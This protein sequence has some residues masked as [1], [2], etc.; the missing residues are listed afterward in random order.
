M[1]Q[2]I[3][4]KLEHQ[5]ATVPERAVDPIA[6]RQSLGVLEN[7]FEVALVELTDTERVGLVAGQL[8][9]RRNLL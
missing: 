5:D 1:R 6:V 7:D 8:Y 2:A 3:L 9:L 4:D